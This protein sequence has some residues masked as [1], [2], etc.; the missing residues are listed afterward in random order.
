MIH[1]GQGYWNSTCRW[2]V[3]EN[4]SGMSEIT[5]FTRFSGARSFYCLDDDD[6]VVVVAGDDFE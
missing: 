3:D 4:Y 6:F 2:G 5:S 1:F